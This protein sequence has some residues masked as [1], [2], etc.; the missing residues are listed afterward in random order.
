[1]ITRL[2]TIEPQK[3]TY[4]RT[5]NR[6]EVVHHVTAAT[7]VSHYHCSVRKTNIAIKKMRQLTAAGAPFSVEFLSH[8]ATHGRSEGV[9]KVSRALLRPGMGSDKSSKG[10]ILIGYKDLDQSGDR[11]FY[12]PLLLKV[13]GKKICDIVL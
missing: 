5:T 11:W 10:S 7:H 1:M 8:N 3:P 2:L 6:R 9:K 13:N 12:A 4:K